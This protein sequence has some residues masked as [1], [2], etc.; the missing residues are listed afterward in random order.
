ML[1]GRVFLCLVQISR[2]GRFWFRFRFLKNGSGGSRSVR[3]PFLE[4]FQ[5]GG[6]GRLSL[7]GVAVMTETAMTA[8][9]AETVK[10]ATV[11]SLCCERFRRFRFPVPVRFLGHPVSEVIFEDLP[12]RPFRTDIRMTSRGLFSR[13]VSR[14]DRTRDCALEGQ[15]AGRKSA[16]Q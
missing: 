9:T 7:R 13:L 15:K 14:A 11:A 4:K 10:T 5:D 8:E 16:H 3:F 12:Q 6:K 2:E 1:W